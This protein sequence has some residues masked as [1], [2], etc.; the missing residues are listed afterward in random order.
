MGGQCHGGLMAMVMTVTT[1][2]V[3]TVVMG[4]RHGDN[5]ARQQWR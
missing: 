2:A 3:T 5:D 1:A 4:K